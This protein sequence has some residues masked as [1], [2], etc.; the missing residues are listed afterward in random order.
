MIETPLLE[1]PSESAR[2]VMIRELRHALF[3]IHLTPL[4]LEKYREDKPRFD[5]VC[6]GLSHECETIAILI[7]REFGREGERT[8]DMRGNDEI[9]G[10]LSCGPPTLPSTLPGLHIQATGEDRIPKEEVEIGLG[11]RSR[12]RAL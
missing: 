12:R 10:V 7:E 1:L 8:G 11:P 6:E 3:T 4:L 2:A 5:E 9:Y